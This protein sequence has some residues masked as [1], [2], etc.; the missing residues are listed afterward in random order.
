MV[1]LGHH[2]EI[3]TRIVLDHQSE[4]YAAFDILLHR[5]SQGDLSIEN[6]VH[7]IR[8]LLRTNAHPVAR[9]TLLQDLI[10]RGRRRSRR[11]GFR[12]S[13]C[14]FLLRGGFGQFRIYFGSLAWMNAV[15]VGVR[16]G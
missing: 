6:H 15:I 14:W 11:R 9:L 3:V 8:L 1:R 13:G 4:L 2:A 10:A 16:L 5:F 7:R 12:W